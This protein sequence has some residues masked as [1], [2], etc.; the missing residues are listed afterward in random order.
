MRRFLLCSCVLLPLAS[1]A[2]ADEGSHFGL[3]GFVGLW[4]G[5]DPVDGGD[6][7]RSITCERDRSCDFRATDSVITLCGG[8]PAFGSGTGGLEDGELVFPDV[9]LTCP[10]GATAN[11]SVRFARDPLNRTLVE[12]AVVDDRTLPNIIF[13]KIS[14]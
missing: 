2:A 13:H 3:R 14:R 4:E 11:L 7:L 5:I 10:D 12:T 8:G 9:V 1:A 6:A